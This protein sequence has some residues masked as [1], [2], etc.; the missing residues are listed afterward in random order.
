FRPD[1]RQ[2]DDDV[3]VRQHVVDVDAELAAGELHRALKEAADL[4]VA[5][6]VAGQRAVAGHVPRDG[7]IEH[8]EDRRDVSL[9]EVFIGFANDRLIRFAHYGLSAHK[10]KIRS[11]RSFELLAHRARVDDELPRSD[12]LGG[13]D[14]AQPARTASNATTRNARITGRY[15]TSRPMPR[16]FV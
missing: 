4:L 15:H 7:G 10:M 16:D 3:T 1:R 2:G 6:V 14:E 8:G 5:L 13:G 11:P 12:C 9:G